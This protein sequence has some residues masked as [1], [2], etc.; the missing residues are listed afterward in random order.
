VVGALAYMY[1]PR[2]PS[3]SFYDENRKVTNF[4]STEDGGIIESTGSDN[5]LYTLEIPEESFWGEGGE[6]ITLTPMIDSSYLPAD[7]SF[8]AGV[9]LDPDG[10]SLLKPATLTI[11]LPTA[12]ASGKVF[13]LC[14]NGPAGEYYTDPLFSF[15]Q[16]SS[17]VTFQIMHFSE[18]V[19]ISA[20]DCPSQHSNPE[21]PEDIY[22]NSLA[23][24]LQTSESFPP[25]EAFDIL[26]DWYRNLVIEELIAATDLNSLDSALR[27]YVEWLTHVNLCELDEAFEFYMQN[28]DV[29]IQR[30]LDQ[31][32]SRLDNECKGTD[33]LCE[34]QAKLNEFLEWSKRTQ[35][36][37]DEYELLINV[38][39]PHDFCD[40]LVKWLVRTVE[41][42]SEGNKVLVGEQIML[43]AV[44]KNGT[45]QAIFGV[46]EL[47]WSSSDSGVARI[48]RTFTDELDVETAIIEG[49]SPGKATI[50]AKAGCDA[51]DHI[52]IEVLGER[53][54]PEEPEEPED[55]GKESSY[56]YEL[57]WKATIDD[58]IT[59][60]TGGNIEY[61]EIHH[62][63][64]VF[65]GSAV[66]ERRKDPTYMNANIISDF[67][68]YGHI[69]KDYELHYSNPFTEENWV[70]P[71]HR[72][73]EISDYGKETAKFL[74][75]RYFVVSKDYIE[76]G[77]SY[78]FN[79]G[80]RD[81]KME[82][83]DEEGNKILFDNFPN[84]GCPW[85]VPCDASTQTCFKETDV[86][87]QTFYFDYAGRDFGKRADMY[88]HWVIRIEPLNETVDLVSSVGGL[89]ETQ[90]RISYAPYYRNMDVAAA[91]NM[92][93][94]SNYPA[95]VVLDVR[96][97]SEYDSG[98]IR[99]AVWIPVTELEAR[100]GELAVHKNQE[101]IVY[102]GSGARSV[103][104]SEIL[105]SHDFT[106]VI[107]M[108]GGISA[109]QSAGYTL[110]PR[111]VSSS[112]P[113]W[114][115]WWFWATKLTGTI[116]LI[117]VVHLLKKRKPPTPKT[118]SQ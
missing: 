115:Q 55:N 5:T 65:E 89:K 38:P 36:L 97:Q 26:L 19:V 57:T 98:H 21:F 45:N 112:P 82:A 58:T 81:S 20:E 31:E 29:E 63:A 73:F 106:K 96:T 39:N 9:R 70:K 30:V 90:T 66:I 59:F 68:V 113:F 76:P 116:A 78:L 12:L 18:R 102:C 17:T 56:K 105:Q 99:G 32:F 37:F 53:E 41:I 104:A 75:E 42:G 72:I 103:T 48:G 3:A 84:M 92:I 40:N 77:L 60:S 25:P 111:V 35:L 34:K 52:V 8:V 44:L 83:I 91:Y 108:V 67:W 7:C 46:E 95:I 87:A 110:N 49:V 1:W 93:S 14:F 27:I 6:N 118:H 33:N 79:T 64:G 100:I 117:G 16:T 107:N 24:A 101:I 50:T 85:T 86:I 10:I 13:G 88:A 61:K 15:E 28:A 69:E 2:T 62:Y 80:E 23:C 43:V 11:K 54:E 22:K 51:V 109:W 94:S 47:E 4:I 114:T 74:I 71:E